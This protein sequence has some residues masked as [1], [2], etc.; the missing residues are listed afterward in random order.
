[1]LNYYYVSSSVVMLVV[2]PV[3]MS[4]LILNGTALVIFGLQ[5]VITCCI[6]RNVPIYFFIHRFA[7]AI[8]LNDHL[9]ELLAIHD[10][11]EEAMPRRILRDVQNLL[12]AYSEAQFVQRYRFSKDVFLHKILPL[13]RGIAHYSNRGRPLPHML[14]VTTALRF[15]ATRSFQVS[16]ISRMVLLSHSM[17]ANFV[18]LKSL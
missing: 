16:E 17:E 18:R 6:S 14:C 3:R 8:I 1:M 13:T 15:Y 9:M 2:L 5:C 10:E 4:Q 11:I 7:M 12:E